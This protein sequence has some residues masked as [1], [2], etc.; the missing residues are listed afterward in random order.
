MKTIAITIDEAM[1]D[2]ID[3]LAGARDGDSP[4]RSRI[5]RTAIKEY[6]DRLEREAEE[7]REREIFRRHRG[8]LQQQVAALVN[9]QAK[10]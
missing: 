4:N 6:L 3:R 8:R 7:E 9:D 10:P 1:L 5:I 2:S